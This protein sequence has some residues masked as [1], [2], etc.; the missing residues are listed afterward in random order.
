MFLQTPEHVQPPSMYTCLYSTLQLRSGLDMR[1][2]PVSDGTDQPA[3]YI[4][5]DMAIPA[6][7]LVSIE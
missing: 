4:Q 5:D 3:N 7:V 2:K 1:T 6:I